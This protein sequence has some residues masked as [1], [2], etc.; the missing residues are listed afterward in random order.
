MASRGLKRLGEKGGAA[1]VAAAVLALGYGLNRAPAGWAPLFHLALLTI[2]SIPA[3]LIGRLPALAGASLAVLS[4]APGWFRTWQ[5]GLVAEFAS[6]LVAGTLCVVAGLVLPSFGERRRVR[7]RLAQ[8]L[9]ETGQGVDPAR[10]LLDE[11]LRVAGVDVG[12]VLLRRD[13]GEGLEQAA[14]RGL[15]SDASAA[16]LE[17][18]DEGRTVARSVLQEGRSCIHALASETSGVTQTIAAVP[19]RG[20]DQVLG[21][22][23]VY[24]RAGRPLGRR[25]LTRLEV[26]ANEGTAILAQSGRL[27]GDGSSPA[28]RMKELVILEEIARTIGASLDLG[29]TLR[30]ILT[31]TRRLIAF[32]MAEVTLWDPARQVLVSRG[33]LDAEAYHAA[34]GKCYKLDDGYSGWLARNRRPLLV[35]DIPGCLEVRPR[36]DQPGTPF[37]SYLGLP[38]ERR[39]EFVGTLELISNRAAAFSER[40]LEILQAIGRHAAT[41]IEHARLYARAERE[42]GR[43]GEALT[44]LQRLTR[45]L[46]ATFDREQ[47]LRLVLEEASRLGRATHSAIL[48]RDPDSE[49]WRLGLC[50]G[51]SDEEQAALRR[52]LESPAEGDALSEVTRT[53]EIVC[54]S[55]AAA[56]GWGILGQGGFRSALLAPIW[57]GDSL[58]GVLALGSR[59]PGAFDAATERSAQALA[60]QTAIAMGSARHHDEQ[61]Q[62]NVLLQRRARQL[63]RVLEVGQAIRSD[64]PVERVLEEIACAVQE[65]VGFDR[66]LVSIVEGDPPCLRPVAGAGIPPQVMERLEQVK[67]PA[68]MLEAV[69]QDDFRISRSYRIPARE[70]RRWPDALDVYK[71]GLAEEAPPGQ[72]PGSGRDTLVVPLLGPGGQV[73]GIL[74]VGEP[75]DESVPGDPTI[76]A[77][78]VFAA[79]A[80]VAVENARLLEALQRRLDTLSVFNDLSRS[81]ARKLELDEV[82]QTVVEATARLVDCTGSVVFLQG[83]EAGPYVARAAHGHDLRVL[84]QLTFAVGQ[85]LVGTVARTGMPLSVAD[86]EGDAAASYVQGG[87]TAL[88]PLSVG[89]QVVGVLAADR[90]R[91]GT[92]APADVAALAALADQVAVAVQN[93]RLYDEAVRRTRELYTLLEAGGALS[94]TLDLSWVLH[95]LGDLLLG[96]AGAYGCLIFEWEREE[97]RLTVVWGVG[98]EDAR[99]LIGTVYQASDQPQ[100][101]ETLLTQEPLLLVAEDPELDARSRSYLE[102]RKT[103]ALLLLP[104]VTRGQTV[105]LVELEPRRGRQPFTAEETRLAQALANQ[106]AAA[107][108][109]ARLYEEIRRFS[110][111]LEQRVEDRT[112]ELARA[113]DDLTT[114]RDRMVA[115]YR[116]ASE[117]SASLDLDRVLNRTLALVVEAVGADEGSVLLDDTEAGQLVCRAAVGARVS[118]PPGGVPANVRRG[119]GVAGSVI[120]RREAV[121]IGD[122]R[123]DPRWEADPQNDRARRA[124]VAIPLGTGGETHGALL[125]FSAT[126]GAFTEGHRRLAEAAGAQIANAIGNAALYSLIRQQ[127]ERLGAM[128]KQQQVEGA[129]SQAVLEGVA[130][131]VMV[132]DASDQV[133]LFNAAAERILEIPRERALGRSTREMLGLYGVEGQAWLATIEDWAADPGDHTPEEFVS[134]RLELEDRV[135]SVHAS[136]VIM[137]SE[138]LGTV[139]VFRDITVAV[140]ADRAKSEF[141]STVSHELRTPMTSIKGY[142]DLLLMGAVGDLGD[143]QRRFLTIIRSNADRLTALVNDLLDISRIETGRVELDLRAV[144]LHEVVKQVTGTLEGK[145]RGQGVRLEARVSEHLPAV[146]SDSARLAQILTNLVGNAIQYTPPGGKVTVSARQ[147]DGML[148]VLVTDT[149]IG[150]SAENQKKIFDRFFRAD[151]PLVRE[152]PGTGLGLPITASLVDLHGGEIWVESEL[153]E[154]STFTFTL[155]LASA[156]QA[157]LPAPRPVGFPV[158]VV[159]DD[160]D[161]ANLIRIHLEME[162]FE[163]ITTERGD[164]ALR[165]ARESHPALITLDIRLPDADGFVILERLKRDPKTAEV[166]VV[167][168]SVVPDKE[169]GL[170]LGA[171][172]YVG[173]PIDEQAL[174]EAVRRVLH[175]RGLILVVDD[176]R[177]SL[178]LMREALRRHGFSVR[179]TGLGRRAFRVARESEPALIL[180]DLKLAD[181]HGYDVLRKLK[182]HPRT[183]DI[184]VVVMTGSLTH[185]EL[186]QQ[187]A[188]ALG[189]ARFLTKPFAVEELIEEISGVLLRAA[190]IRTSDQPV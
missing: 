1:V 98:E 100:L 111:E 142:A 41:A 65:S 15:G 40:D 88:V 25:E 110:E 16:I 4:L 174:L 129:K 136:P 143:E 125:L 180:L 81:V 152:S 147:E 149:G 44:G 24:S 51:Y 80:A 8:R 131:G 38:L 161:V 101:L 151:D 119:E 178:S 69:M 27:S 74:A 118:I 158:L 70:Q 72:E 170:R 134:E 83:V 14:A 71:N 50:A 184:P 117:V 124:C 130:D 60:A 21:V 176:D 135:V 90:P 32:D 189:A 34:V 31:S 133:I 128:L 5:A 19:L 113:L 126:P 77:L 45:E 75:R 171:V 78:E 93:S 108:Q 67:Q 167:I 55:D 39:G 187:Q 2:V 177:D 3:L 52:R 112:R 146:W 12:E 62:L 150:I 87:A 26:V 91:E 10:L 172:D 79:Q 43:R 33:S 138:Y 7:V 9:G 141:V 28:K 11:A 85:G 164:E 97:D 153:G 35:A 107:V 160:P 175:K 18:H 76:E 182:A 89:E 169:K 58:A 185:E 127:A 120:E 163:V 144:H 6:G 162:G 102:R 168:V 57:Y 156:E 173:K 68:K 20:A 36:L 42:L 181:S 165:L 166:P 84:Q 23:C 190:R 148:E 186:K 116:I 179:T 115:L 137:G 123:E 95:S 63:S 64:Q 17:G 29:A 56:E 66:V 132:A 46:S 53:G 104:M 61:A 106:A 188:L 183:C 121:L 73:Q 139:S 140:E 86:G 30:A 145:A 49:R 154:G 155:P 59:E 99:S 103:E 105:G 122:L 114:E 48:L 22:L 54:L 13:G 94:S 82:L 92:F 37:R 159:E 157:A 96:V 47:V 109:N